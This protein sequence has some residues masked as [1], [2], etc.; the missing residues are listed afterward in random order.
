MLIS[1]S[2]LNFSHVFEAQIS[3]QERDVQAL[4]DKSVYLKTNTKCKSSEVMNA[5]LHFENSRIM[6]D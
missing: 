1:A 2:Y 5:D 6:E 4:N 3:R